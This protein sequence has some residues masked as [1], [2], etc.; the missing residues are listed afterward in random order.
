MPVFHFREGDSPLLVSM[1][2][3]GTRVPTEMQVNLT[4]EA[5]RLPDTDWYVERLY[6]FLPEMGVSVVQAEYS[7]YVIDL[8]RS[9]T[10]GNLYPG[11]S[12]TELCP[13]TLFSGA[14]VYREGY[15]L[16]D[17]DLAE[18]AANYWQP[19]HDK[20][21]AELARIKARFGYA[22]LWDAHSIRS[23]VPRFFEGSLPDFNWG[24][25]NGNS[26]SA[27]LAEMLLSFS[28]ED[29]GYSAVLDGRFKGGY[30]TRTYGVP[31]DNSHA[32]QLEL[33][34][35]TYLSDEAAFEFC[36]EKAAALRSLLRRLIGAVLE[37]RG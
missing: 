31:A 10:G 34:Q 37:F 27:A 28:Q 8:N 11:R 23:Q 35:A 5:R 14:P 26:C 32:V 4:E 25:G 21:Q 6:D 7:R 13:T 1:P 9:M 12:V 3:V 36:E 18:R 2:H 20:L 29:H 17:D 16:R 19:Y 24:T 33:S 30:I 15:Q 22:L